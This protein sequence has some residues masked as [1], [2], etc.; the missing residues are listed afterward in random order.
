MNRSK[1]TRLI[2]STKMSL[3]K[4]SP[5]IL[6]GIGIAG[7]VT[8]AVLAVKATPKA[9]DLIAEAEDEKGEHLTKKETVEVTWKCYISAMVTGVSSVACL[10]GSSKSS[11]K[12]Y[13]ALTAAYKVAETTIS[14]YKDYKERVIETIG[15]EKEKII[16]EKVAEKKLKEKPASKSDVI[17]TSSNAEQLFYDAIS[18]RYFK[19]DI[20]TIDAAV[21]KLNANMINDIYGCTSLNEFYAEIGMKNCDAGDILGWNI[22]HRITVDYTSMLTDDMRSCIVLDFI[23]PPTYNFNIC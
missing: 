1:L 4:H 22:D 20:N 2:N 10:I 8:T 23:E 14:D 21:N 17:I 16:K 13:A 18:G 3:S 11:A 19:S 15:E 7:M 9:L 5:E 12:R 6:M